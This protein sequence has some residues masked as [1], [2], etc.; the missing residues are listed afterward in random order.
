M[1]RVSASELAGIGAAAALLLLATELV[2]PLLLGLVGVVRIERRPPDGILLDRG[3]GGEWQ[4]RDR[5]QCDHEKTRS[6]HRKSSS[7]R[8]RA[9]RHGS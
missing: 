1:P 5:E 4:N 9:A 6:A 7:S 3:V 8:L 2:P